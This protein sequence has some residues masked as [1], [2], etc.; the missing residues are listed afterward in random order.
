MP[1]HCFKIR[2]VITLHFHHQYMRIPR[3]SLILPT[4]DTAHLMDVYWFLIIILPYIFL[5]TN[6]TDYLL[7]GLFV[8]HVFLVEISF[9]T[10]FFF[11]FWVRL[12]LFVVVIELWVI[13]IFWL[14]VLYQIYVLQIFSPSLFIL[15]TVSFTEQKFQFQESPT[16]FF[17][18]HGLCFLVMYCKSHCQTQGH[19][20]F[21]LCSI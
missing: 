2:I 4:L 11:F 16:F 21:L 5:V 20:D 19:L 17:F 15:L 9:Q 6:Y 10:F 8:I 18:S 14:K 1:N 7:M 12:C 3:G 13:H